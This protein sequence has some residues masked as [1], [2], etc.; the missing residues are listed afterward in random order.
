MPA[1][2]W[3]SICMIYLFAEL[4]AACH[5]KSLA[6]VSDV[7]RHFQVTPARASWVIGAVAVAAA[8]FA[9][10]GGWMIDRVGEL[11]AIRIGLLIAM[12]CSFGGFLAPDFTTLIVLRLIEG[13]GYIAVVLGALALLIRTTEGARQ[14]AALSL[15]SVASPMGGA[16][17]IMAV[18]PLVGTDKW[19]WV[20]ACHAL[21]LF[22]A[23]W[24]TPLLP[25]APPREIRRE[26][27]AQSLAIYRFPAVR[28]FLGAIL[29][30]QI[31]KL[32][33]GSALPTFLMTVHHVPP[34]WIGAIS[35]ISIALSVA[36]GVLAG[37]LFNR[38]GGAGWPAAIATIVSAMGAFILYAPVPTFVALFAMLISSISGGVMF[39]WITSS[40]PK[41][42]PDASRV[43]A[44]AGA[45]SQL[46]YLS[47]S[48][49]PVLMFFILEQPSRL[50]LFAVITLSYGL[51]LAV[52]ALQRR[53]AIADASS[54]LPA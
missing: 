20:F 21:L 1:G 13:V 28:L 10:I 16:L 2:T 46:L 41:I 35:A 4:I 6:L 42:T 32:G 26:P 39:A 5:G 15:W 12:L 52:I 27:I 11:R 50:P 45:V 18:S 54:P 22:I 37:A 23:F 19:Q 38:R 31:F 29:L 47:M 33:S 24:F 17:A 25:V 53:S 40:I 36:G 9:P 30:V 3:R 51:P 14:T 7:A 48:I 8:I 49:G 34:A 44:A 43:G